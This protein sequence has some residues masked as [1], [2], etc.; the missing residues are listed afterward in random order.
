V[1]KTLLTVIVPVHK[2]SGR[3]QRLRRWAS[4]IDASRQPIEI[5]MIEDGM[6]VETYAELV[7]IKNE[8]CNTNIELLQVDTK[9]PGGARNYGLTRAKGDWIAFWDSDD[10]IVINTVIESISDWEKNKKVHV[11]GYQTID[12]SRED[13][14][15]STNISRSLNDLVC[16]LGLWRMFFQ[17][18]FIDNHTF[19]NLR[20]GEDQVF[21][22]KLAI[23][24]SEVAF[25]PEIVYQYVRNGSNQLTNNPI[26]I[27][28]IQLCLA[29][30]A[31]ILYRRDR[32]IGV[33]ISMYNRQALTAVRKLPLKIKPLVLHSYLMVFLR[34]PLRNKL[35]LFLSLS[36][37]V[38]FCYI[39][40]T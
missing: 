24:E 38:T 8:L 20:M 37:V 30:L 16:E 5:L 6:H 2:M 13:K 19:P 32:S 27:E 9:S 36:K 15:L 29:H 7:D 33:V 12:A 34:V 11:Y 21:F 17:R 3:L 39:K 28:D 4:Q 40:R 23:H 35:R 14:I 31:E 18:E 10:E 26:A 1:N 25:H 22:A